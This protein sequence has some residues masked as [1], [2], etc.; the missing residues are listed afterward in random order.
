MLLRQQSTA[1]L[2][3]VN[4][5]ICV[6]II[7]ST[8]YTHS[9]LIHRACA[10][11]SIHISIIQLHK[12]TTSS[13]WSSCRRRSQRHELPNYLIIIRNCWILL[14]SNLVRAGGVE[15]LN[16]CRIVTSRFSN[17]WSKGRER[18]SR[19]CSASCKRSYLLFRCRRNCTFCLLV[20]FRILL[21]HRIF[22]S[23]LIATRELCTLFLVSSFLCAT[24]R[25]KRARDLIEIKFKAYP[26]SPSSRDT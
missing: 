14:I 19:V 22:P 25:L 1:V 17:I 20:P 4:P 26:S 23:Q 24:D 2:L 18:E 5:C 3:A 16:A 7:F 13:Y 21:R 15:I 9:T 10:R 12:L 6:G 11:D 8:R